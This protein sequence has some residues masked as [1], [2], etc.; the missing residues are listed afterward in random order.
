MPPGDR[1]QQFRA[2]ARMPDLH[3]SVANRANEAMKTLTMIAGILVMIMFITGMYGT[4]F[5]HMPEM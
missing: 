3:T 5:A 1:W 4:N 2:D